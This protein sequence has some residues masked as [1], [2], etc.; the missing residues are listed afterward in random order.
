[1]SASARARELWRHIR[2]IQRRGE[3]AETDLLELRAALNELGRVL[4]YNALLIEPHRVA[5]DG[6]PWRWISEPDQMARWELAK[7]LADELDAAL[8]ARAAATCGANCSRRTACA[9]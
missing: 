7:R 3:L 8:R 1:V 9:G 6:R 5:A 4:D 2:T